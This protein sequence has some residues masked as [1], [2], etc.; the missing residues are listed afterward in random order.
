[1]DDMEDPATSALPAGVDKEIIKEA[2]DSN[3]NSP[4]D[5][6]EVTVHYV[7]TLSD[8]SEFDSSRSKGK[9]FNFTL[10]RGDVI[11][12]WDLGVA[13]MRKGE[14]AKFTLAPEYA[15]GDAGS[16][17][18]IPE[19]A[20]LVFEVELLN[21]VSKDDLFSDGGVI[22]VLVKEGSGWKVPKNK[23]EQRISLKCCKIDGSIIEDRGSFDYA[24]GSGALGPLTKAVEKA[25]LTMKKGE[26]CR[27]TCRQDY[28]YGDGH[29]DVAL[30]LVLEELYEI[31]DVSLAKDKSIMK[32]QIK[33]GEGFEK[34]KECWKVWSQD[35]LKVLH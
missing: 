30:D 14:V 26:E 24:I 4:K 18:T 31:M 11:R 21:F 20:T 16:P 32:K 25:L 17:P 29:G 12:G 35:M 33:E 9:P 22:K 23:G 28:A 10:G 6:D 7:G 2:P 1:M 27:L 19:K 13:S 15:Y 3:F 5:G 34:P 8:G